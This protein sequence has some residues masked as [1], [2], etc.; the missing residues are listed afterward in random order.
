MISEKDF[1][2]IIDSRVL[3][4][5]RLRVILKDM[6]SGILNPKG[7]P[8]GLGRRKTLAQLRALGK[9]QFLQWGRIN[10]W[11]DPCNGLAWECWPR[12][13]QRNAP[14]LSWAGIFIA[15]NYL[16]KIPNLSRPH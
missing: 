16:R 1:T 13:R 5:V 15:R 4:A 14:F 7:Y 12:E 6:R 11:G 10:F 9:R 8:L 2:K 3:L